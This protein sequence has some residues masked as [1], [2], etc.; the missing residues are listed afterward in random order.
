MRFPSQDLKESVR[1][2][3]VLQVFFPF[4]SLSAFL[5]MTS[6]VKKIAGVWMCV[7]TG[8][9]PL[10]VMRYGCC[11]CEMDALGGFDVLMHGFFH[12]RASEGGKTQWPDLLFLT[13]SRMEYESGC[14]GFGRDIGGWWSVVP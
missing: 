1:T 7:L 2:Q 4:M 13:I 3:T 14:W 8:I 5:G 10:A 12:R 9:L 6:M 11:L